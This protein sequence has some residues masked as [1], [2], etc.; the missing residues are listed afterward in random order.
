MKYIV[1]KLLGDFFTV[2]LSCKHSCINA[3]K[4]SKEEIFKESR[5]TNLKSLLNSKNAIWQKTKYNIISYDYIRQKK[6]A[7]FFLFQQILFAGDHMSYI[8]SALFKITLVVNSFQFSDSLT[9]NQFSCMWLISIEVWL[10]SHIL[11]LLFEIIGKNKKTE[12]VKIISQKKISGN[13]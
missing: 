2:C 11:L 12:T 9:Q 4:H 8:L 10:I 6:S 13:L 3:E 5:S 7:V 1:T